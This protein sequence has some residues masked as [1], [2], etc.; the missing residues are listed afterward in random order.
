MVE[1]E[2]RLLSSAV[3]DLQQ[4]LLECSICPSV[5]RRSR[6]GRADCDVTGQ[7]GAI[8]HQPMGDTGNVGRSV[9][10]YDVPQELM[11]CTVRDLM[12]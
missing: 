6:R 5:P 1:R 11:K 10:C 2:M 4:R 8:R 3:S 7:E 9:A 12:E